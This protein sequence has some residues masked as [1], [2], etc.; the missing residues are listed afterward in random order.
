[1]AFSTQELD[2]IA[3]ATLD[4]YIRGPAFSQIIQDRP[5]YDAL[6]KTQKTTPG[7]KGD[8]SLPVKGVYTT[9]VAGYTHDDE[10]TYVNPANIRR[11]NYPWREHHAGIGIT[12]T[13]LKHSGIS[14]VDSAQSKSTSQ[15]SDS[16][17]V[18]LTNLL[19][20]KLEDMA[21]GWGRSFTNLLH[22]NG[23]GD[24]KALAGIRALLPDNP[25]AGTVGGINRATTTWWRHRARTVAHATAT[26]A[27]NGAINTSTEPLDNL[28]HKEM[29]QL[30]RYGGRP[31]I[32]LCGSDFLDALA[33]RLRDKGNYTETGWSGGAKDISM[34]DIKYRNVPFVY[35]PHMDDLSLAKRC[36]ILDTS[37]LYLYVMEGEDMKRH[38]PA[39]PHNR[40]V[41]YRAMTW[42]GQL[43]L[44]QSNAQG[45]Y[46]I[47]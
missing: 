14:V 40:Y 34:A 42:T 28:I 46:D 7:G 27:A 4:H 12:L 45:V 44:Q 25:T 8:I 5:I 47:V 10:V 17:L 36:Y 31:S 24:P 20:D 16:D 26:T 6:R 43:V 37:K 9:S 2:N 19:Q 29:R 35:D 33:A 1:M 32:A 18:V 39:R 41:M 23:T 38:T 13:E 11:V 21:E 22:G 3:N 15:H 30:K